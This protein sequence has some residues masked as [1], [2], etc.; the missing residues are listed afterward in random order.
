MEQAKSLEE[1]FIE[2]S[3]EQREAIRMLLKEK[4]GYPTKRKRHL[5]S[6]NEPDIIKW[7]PR[8]DCDNCTYQEIQQDVNNPN[9]LIQGCHFYFDR[10][11]NETLE[12]IVCSKW[13]NRKFASVSTEN[14]EED[15]TPKR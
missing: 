2:A 1:C 13:A 3:S 4:A 9:I 11:W 10:K 6:H 5:G 15:E 14:E 7:L 12:R 8:K